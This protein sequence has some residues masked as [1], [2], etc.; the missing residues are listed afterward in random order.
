LDVV[1]AM[2]E[3]RREITDVRV[4]GALGHP[5][6]VQLLGYLLETGPRTATQCAEVV[7][8]SPSAC[9]Y[10][11]RHMARFGLVERADG[12]HGARRG[13]GRE[14]LWR[15]SSTGYVFGGPPSEENPALNAARHAVLVAGID[16]NARLAKRYLGDSE[17]LSDEWRDAG[18]FAAYGLLV[19][20]DEL[21]AL[22]QAVDAT[23]RPFIGATRVDAP[24]GAERVHVTVQ[25]FRRTDA[26]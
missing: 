16:D 5:V 26:S 8:A 18:G 3:S 11:L 6:R 19:T 12:P 4:L 7:D 14:R 2:P 10:H 22:V 17:Q 21:A 25:A 1:M 9:S 15:A 23:L 24:D 20:A 13:D